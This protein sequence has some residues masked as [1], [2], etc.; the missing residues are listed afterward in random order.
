MS[1]R[2]D[3]AGTVGDKG[4]EGEEHDGMKRSV[5]RGDSRNKR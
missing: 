1:R 2:G 3:V 4:G 5:R